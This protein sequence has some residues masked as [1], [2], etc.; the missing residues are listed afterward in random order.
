MLPYHQMMCRDQNVFQ[1]LK[2]E[3][4]SIH[5]SLQG[6]SPV[7]AEMQYIREIQMMDGYGIEYYTAKV[8]ISNETLSIHI[9]LQG[10]SPVKAEMQYIRE[11][12]MMDGYGIEYYTAKVALLL[13]IVPKNL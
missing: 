13:Y 9:S 11:I 2:N 7:K 1:E 8:F 10:V 5:V 3:T 4:L 6:V 12:Q